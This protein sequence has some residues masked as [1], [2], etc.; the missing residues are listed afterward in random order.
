MTARTLEELTAGLPPAPSITAADVAAAQA[1]AS[2]RPFHVV[3]DDDPTGTQSVSGIPVLTAWEVDDFLWAFGTGAGA[4]Y[5][6]TNSRSLPPAD[7]ESVNREVVEAALTAAERARLDVAF[8]S[9]SDSTLRGHFPLEPETI[10]DV[11]AARTGAQVDGIVIVPAFSDAGRMTIHGTHYAGSPA[12]G[13]VPVGESEFARDNTFGYSSSTLPQWVEEKSGGRISAG[14]VLVLDIETLR[15]DPDATV[16]LLRSARDRRPIAVDSVDDESDLRALALALIRAEDAGS[17]FI[18]RVG[19]PFGRARFGQDKHAPLTPDE[20]D[21]SRGD[22]TCSA[23]GLVV[24]GSHVGM[25]RRQLDALVERL[26][27][28]VAVI[29]SARVIEE[30]DADAHLDEIAGA[31]ASGL[32]SSTVVLRTSRALLDGF[33]PDTALAHS[34]RISAAVVDVVQRVLAR[35]SPRF[36]VA[37][38]GITSSDVASKGLRIRRA[39]AVGPMLPGIISLWSAQDGPAAGIPYVV[40]PG[41]V[42]DDQSLAD[43]V[44]TLSS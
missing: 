27:P 36:V 6:M 12:T 18:Y 25:T 7:A 16:A 23:G 9:R 1:A 40:F 30:R 41:N 31:I 19:P 17:R 39:L 10:A 43:V 22:R 3:L 44:E 34:R 11:L 2:T 26:D 42:G 28:P 14:D 38:G 8:V 4:V 35:T 24:V 21:A 15:A 13:Y 5:V 32:D 33:D 29:D 37:K 20:I